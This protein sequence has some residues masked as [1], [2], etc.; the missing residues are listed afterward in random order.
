MKTFIKDL[1]KCRNNIMWTWGLF[2]L[3]TFFGDS[4]HNRFE[5]FMISGLA[6]IAV[7]ILAI[8]FMKTNLK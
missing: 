4:P 6:A 7:T 5:L 3:F 1:W 2:F 8:L